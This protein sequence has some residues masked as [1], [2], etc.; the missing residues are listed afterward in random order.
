MRSDLPTR[1]SQI[2]HRAQ[3]AAPHRFQERALGFA[4]PEMACDGRDRCR[5]GDWLSGLRDMRLESRREDSSA[6]FSARVARQCDRGEKT[7]VFGFI[8]PNLSNQRRPV[9]IREVEI[10]DQGVRP[11]LFEYLKR[12]SDRRHRFH[13]GARLRQYQ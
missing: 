6:I 12:F 9:L 10:A 13:A 1:P 3:R 8:L 5:Q 4:V 11:L 2:R 7:T